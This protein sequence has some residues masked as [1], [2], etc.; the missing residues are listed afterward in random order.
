MKKTKSTF[1]KRIQQL[2]P[3]PTFALDEMVKQMQSKGT[4]IINLG[5][6]EPDFNT[7]SHISAAAIHAINDGFTHYTQTAGI[8]ELRE[9][10]SQKFQ[11]DNN[12]AYNPSH[13]LVGAGSKPLLYFAF[14]AL[15][16]KGDE[17]I[18]PVPTWASYVE[19]IKLTG[20]KPVLLHLNPPFKLTAKALEGKITPST[21]AIL[22]N[23]P[24]NPT[25]AII[26]KKELEKIAKLALKNDVYII[27]DEI[28]E[29]I[30]YSGEHISIASL[31]KQ[32]ADRAITING[33]SKTYAMTG[34][35]IGYAG[36]PSEII[37]AMTNLQGQLTA[38]ASSISQKAA[39]Q[40]LIGT[41]DPVSAMIRE[42]AKRRAFLVSQLSQ[43]A[44][45]EVIPPEGSFYFFVGIHKLLGGKYRTSADWCADLL[46]QKKVALIPGEAFFAPGFFRLSFT[47]P[48]EKL[49]KAVK[50]IKEFINEK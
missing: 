19:Q 29:K 40:A 1:A 18:V 31:G 49:E 16:Q 48:L 32:I 25:G 41:N 33:F 12:I 26:D 17:V 50:K 15:C 27:S 34:W 23:S 13:I 38:N 5:L 42:F 47:T 45:L 6:G 10:I 24:S 30:I 2:E 7:P 22:L 9:A 44:E 43:I 3:S 28:Y 35:R 4:S 8:P 39:L 14:Q 37:T 20:S 11:A 46:S 21:K 36:G